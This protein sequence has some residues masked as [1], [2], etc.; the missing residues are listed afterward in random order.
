MHS[1][2]TRRRVAQIGAL[3]PFASERL[4]EFGDAFGHDAAAHPLAASN[5]LVRRSGIDEA[6][7]LGLG[8]ACRTLF[9][10]IVDTLVAGFA[11]SLS[12]LRL[13][14]DPAGSDVVGGY[15]ASL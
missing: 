15:L 12:Q 1:G 8:A 4:V 6:G 3:P 2:K 10:F 9:L 7:G 14:N 11:E 5:L 13:V